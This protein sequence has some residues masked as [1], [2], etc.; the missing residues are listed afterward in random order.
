MP[1][2]AELLLKA[3]CPN[4]GLP[5]TECVRGARASRRLATLQG[6]GKLFSCLPQMVANRQGQRLG[7]E[8]SS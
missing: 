1:M 5:V 6:C 4:A 2:V 7:R 8:S 3:G